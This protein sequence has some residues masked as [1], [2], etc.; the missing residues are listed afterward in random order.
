MGVKLFGHYLSIAD[1]YL[2]QLLVL[3]FV[4]Y[5]CVLLT[6]KCL[7]MARISVAILLVLGA[8]A[9]FQSSQATVDPKTVCY[10]E[11]W[12]HWRNGDGKVE[13]SQLGEFGNFR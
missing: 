11:S 3:H 9:T 7:I 1:P 8:L 6:Y 5:Q 13:P 12:V 4:L 10:F 2:Q